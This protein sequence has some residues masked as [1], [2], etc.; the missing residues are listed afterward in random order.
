M[1]PYRI[2]NK[3]PICY[4]SYS[5]QLTLISLLRLVITICISTVFCVQCFQTSALSNEE[6]LQ[7]WRLHYL[8][9]RYKDLQR[10]YPD[11]AVK[12]LDIPDDMGTASPCYPC[13]KTLVFVQRR[14]TALIVHHYLRSRGFDVNVVTGIPRNHEWSFGFGKLAGD[15]K[16]EGKICRES[17]NDENMHILYIE[18]E[19]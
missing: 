5:A 14:D 19:S 12:S 15:G 2:D 17:H 16:D 10:L 18:R 11:E 4:L 7:C 1:E 6:A 3:D 8:A 9:G 13:P